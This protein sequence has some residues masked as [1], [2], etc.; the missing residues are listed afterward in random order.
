MT[1]HRWVLLL[2]MLAIVPAGTAPAQADPT[3]AGSK[4]V[5]KRIR[6]RAAPRPEAS[7][8]LLSDFIKGSPAQQDLERRDNDLA[9]M[10]PVDHRKDEFFSDWRGL[11]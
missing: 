6:A 2:A 4:A 10:R 5:A 11:R 7:G 9:T 3:L 1:V 8:H